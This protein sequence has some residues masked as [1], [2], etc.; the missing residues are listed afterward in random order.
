MDMAG[1]AAFFDESIPDSAIPFREVVAGHIWK[2]GSHN[3]I[4]RNADASA[5]RRVS[6][7]VPNPTADRMKSESEK[8]D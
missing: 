2:P 1:F 5:S 6:H 7:S 8:R 4:L 3:R